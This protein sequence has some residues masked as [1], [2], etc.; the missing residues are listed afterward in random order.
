MEQLAKGLHHGHRVAVVG[1]PRGGEDTSAWNDSGGLLALLVPMRVQHSPTT[2]PEPDEA[3]DHTVYR[4]HRH[5]EAP[6]IADGPGPT[7]AGD[8]PPDEPDEPDDEAPDDTEEDAEPD[9]SMADL[10]TQDG[11]AWTS[12]GADPNGVLE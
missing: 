8:D 12:M 3:D 4:R 11:S 2:E 7:C 9:R 10:L 1:L 6:V 5:G